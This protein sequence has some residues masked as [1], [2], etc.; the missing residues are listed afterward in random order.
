MV[1]GVRLVEG[2]YMQQIIGI[3]AGILGLIGYIPYIMSIL[4]N[5]TRP[6]KASWFI[7]TVVGGLLAFSYMAEGDPN[8]IWLPL[9]YFFGPLI[10]AIL[11]LRYGYA[12]WSKLDK[13]CIIVAI[14]SIIPWL[15]SKSAIITLL[16]NVVIDAAGG[17]PTIVKSYREPETED[18]TAWLIFFIANTMQLFA[19]SVWNLSAIYPIYLFFLA[20]IIVA[21]I[22]KDKIKKMCAFIW[23]SRSEK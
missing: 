21:L 17:I 2:S 23:R 10:V 6:N 16:I 14:I 15:L 5:K 11:S 8:A 7:W 3:V 4:K 9:G 13:I 19:V 18:F 22:I 12:V 20:G 1:H